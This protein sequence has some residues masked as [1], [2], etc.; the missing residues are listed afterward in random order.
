[1]YWII[2]RDQHQVNTG[3]EL[4]I[5]NR[6]AITVLFAN[7]WTV[8]SWYTGWLSSWPCVWNGIVLGVLG[9]TIGEEEYSPIGSSIAFLK[10][11][12]GG[13]Q[14]GTCIFS[15][16]IW[17]LVLLTSS[18][19]PCLGSF[20]VSTTLNAWPFK[21]AHCFLHIR[22]LKSSSLLNRAKNSWY[23]SSHHLVLVNIGRKWD[24]ICS[25]NGLARSCKGKYNHP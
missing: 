17:H 7:G 8:E 16:I 23:D 24:L 3:V 25:E 22:T 18:N 2:L 14:Q 10:M 1:M 21:T 19:G 15:S 4:T 11:D 13:G 5:C 12:T 6:S 20:K 9:S